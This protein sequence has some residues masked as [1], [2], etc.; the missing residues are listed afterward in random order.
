MHEQQPM[1]PSE[2]MTS[3]QQSRRLQADPRDILGRWDLDASRYTPYITSLNDLDRDFKVD[4]ATA[5]AIARF[6]VRHATMYA[7]RLAGS[8][9]TT[10]FIR[11]NNGPVTITATTRKGETKKITVTDGTEIVLSNMSLLGAHQDEKGPSHI[12]LYRR[13]DPKSKHLLGE[14]KIHPALTPLYGPSR[15]PYIWYIRQQF[16]DTP[17]AGCSGLRY[18]PPS[19]PTGCRRW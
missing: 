10:M 16:G 2:N 3:E 17:R 5:D 6:R 12:N 7:H 8:A 19:S 4:V 1:S 13:L 15:H 9:V 14:P 18:S 11:S